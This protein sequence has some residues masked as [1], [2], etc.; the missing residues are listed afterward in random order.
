MID[1]GF[2]Q[3]MLVEQC[4]VEMH[5]AHAQCQLFVVYSPRAMYKAKSDNR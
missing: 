1:V 5:V 2:P 4:V 3:S